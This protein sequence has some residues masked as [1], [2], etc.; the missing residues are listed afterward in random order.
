MPS[1]RREPGLPTVDLRPPAR[2]ESG[3]GAPS[4]GRFYAGVLLLA[5]ASAVVGLALELALSMRTGEL[6]VGTLDHGFASE[7]RPAGWRVV[8]PAEGG[9]LRS[10]DVVLSVAGVPAR[11]LLESDSV[12]RRLDG[13]LRAGGSVSL[14]L[15]REPAF[16]RRAFEQW[17]LLLWSHTGGG[18]TSRSVTLDS[19]RAGLGLA[20]TVRRFDPSDPSVCPDG[21]GACADV[22]RLG[23]VP[24]GLDLEGAEAALRAHD[25]GLT[26]LPPGT[27]VELGLR[28]DDMA[29]ASVAVTAPGQPAVQ[30]EHDGTRWQVIPAGTST[31]DVPLVRRSWTDSLEAVVG[32]AVLLLV[33]TVGL[34][35]LRARSASAAVLHLVRLATVAGLMSV[36]TLSLSWQRWWRPFSSRLEFGQETIAIPSRDGTASTVSLPSADILLTIGL[37]GLVLGTM[38]VVTLRLLHAFPRRDPELEK[39][40]G[41]PWR[42]LTA[43]VL[44]AAGSTW[45]FV[46]DWTAVGSTVWM[47]RAVVL[48]GSTVGFAAFVMLG[49]VTRLAIARL[50]QRH[51]GEEA[52]QARLALFGLGLGAVLLLGSAL[53]PTWYRLSV[54]WSVG[55]Y[56]AVHG[57]KAAVVPVGIAL[58]FLGFFLAIARRGLWDVD[59]IIERATL[60]SVLT[61]VFVVAWLGLEAA[62]EGLLASSLG[63]VP[64]LGDL[65]PPLLAGGL[66]AVS[67]S[68]VTSVLSG[69]LGP[70]GASPGEVVEHLTDALDELAEP[71][72]LPP[73]IVAAFHERMRAEHCALLLRDGEETRWRAWSAGAGVPVAAVAAAA[74]DRLG[75]ARHQVVITDG[76]PS[77]VSRVDLAREHV[78]VLVLG[79]RAGDAFYPAEER[80][81]L[82]LFLGAVAPRLPAA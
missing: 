15:W 39:R 79:M 76:G 70:R 47:L 60:V 49:Q 63:G 31:V 32:Q 2:E 10:R 1:S 75:E 3:I 51:R 57:A 17:S 48:L 5:A 58:P 14:E 50:R 23:I 41:I 42:G 54:P 65:V 8:S 22:D 77:L 55:L 81:T 44:L 62:V 59:V 9:A 71:E 82:S 21:P 40:L 38:L 30:L 4:G 66:A 45:L 35:A 73:A 72:A 67:R 53:F 6:P 43:A 46:R 28:G 52:L 25:A 11:A 69:R 78:G 12:R 61:A 68:S 74:L 13:L 34:L 19:A 29:R 20:A 56:D 18:V 27:E 24:A 64:V 7:V 26:A 33:A 36:W 80:R 16:T 37:L